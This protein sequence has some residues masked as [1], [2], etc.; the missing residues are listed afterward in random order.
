MRMWLG[1]CPEPLENLPV[2]WGRQQTAGVKKQRQGKVTVAGAEKEMV[3]VK[4][5]GAI[6]SVSTSSAAGGRRWVPW[7]VAAAPWRE[8]ARH[9]NLP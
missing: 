5:R 4:K 8:M 1:A 3:L 6:G 2:Q 9:L 7:R